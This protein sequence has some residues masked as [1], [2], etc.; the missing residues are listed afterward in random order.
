MLRLRQANLSFLGVGVLPVQDGDVTDKTGELAL[1][2]GGNFSR[3]LFPSLLKVDELYFDQLM[4]I[5][6]LAHRGDQSIDE[7]MFPN[8][9]H[10]LQMMGQSSEI[11]SV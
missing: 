10:L 2:P 1:C 6:R 4:G 8:L 9:H 11:P 7:A 5:Q 3:Q